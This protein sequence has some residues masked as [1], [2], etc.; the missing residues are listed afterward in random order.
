MVY[1]YFMLMFFALGL[2][3]VHAGRQLL[4]KIRARRLQLAGSNR[5]QATRALAT[6]TEHS[7]DDGVLLAHEVE[8]SVLRRESA[9]TPATTTLIT[10]ENGGFE[11][12]SVQEAVPIVHAVE[13]G[14]LRR[15]IFR[16]FVEVQAVQSARAVRSGARNDEIRRELNPCHLTREASPTENPW[17][18]AAHRQSIPVCT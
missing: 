9:A 8:L 7:P 10:V 4:N 13:V 1:F 12:D 6:S 15:A 5:V 16:R 18:F 11:S 17:E 3:L 14:A 2:R